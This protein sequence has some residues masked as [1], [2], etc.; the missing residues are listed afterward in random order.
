M[1]G[2]MTNRGPGEPRRPHF[3]DHAAF[4]LLLALSIGM[5]AGGFWRWPWDHDEVLAFAELGLVP[6]DQYVGP[7]EQLRRIKVILPVWYHAQRFALSWLPHDEFGARV[8]PVCAAVVLVCLT[9]WWARR[10]GVWFASGVVLLAGASPMLIWLAQ[11][12]RFYSLALLLMA[13]ALFAA[14]S[15]ASGWWPDLW[16]SLCCL[17]ALLTHNL[18]LVVFV[19]A[20][21]AAVVTQLA[22]RNSTL[23]MRRTGLMAAVSVGVYILYLRPA[24]SG[25]VSGG[26]GGT[27][28]AVSYLAQLGLGPLGLALLGAA[29][30][31]TQEDPDTDDLWWLALAAGAVAFVVVVP[32]V[33]NAWN[34][35]YALFFMW[36][37]W[38]VAALG[39]RTVSERLKSP[40]LRAAWLG[41]ILL[42]LA[43]KLLSHLSDGSRHD[44]RSAATVV[45]AEAPTTLLSN[46]PATLQYYVQ[47]KG[48]P[49]VA[50]WQPG[51]A[52]PAGPVMLVFASNAWQP[53][54]TVRDRQVSVVGEVMRRRF[55]EQS[56]VIR[57]YRLGPR[58]VDRPS[59]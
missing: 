15:R 43:P 55:D 7:P 6:A 46:W 21:A 33:L 26:T 58:V 19:I 57:I 41:A 2:G 59:R 25:W 24:L 42:I 40:V 36:P 50:D 10:R 30:I 11:Q 54:M 38:I 49:R 5:L 39:T 35:R 12:N 31:V 29:A 16:A 22:G 3:T 53:V 14:S 44:F 27:F 47:D 20:F 37:F 17:G 1:S 9:A 18:T 52:L 28:P 45:Q 51:G 8:L 23:L 48:L 56:H 13:A 34:P 4:A 32:L